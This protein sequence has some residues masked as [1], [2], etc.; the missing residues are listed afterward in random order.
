MTVNRLRLDD[1]LVVTA[2]LVDDASLAHWVLLSAP[3]ALPTVSPVRNTLN[4]P[5]ATSSCHGKLPGGLINVDPPAPPPSPS[6]AALPALRAFPSRENSWMACA[7]LCTA[8][9]EYLVLALVLDQR[10]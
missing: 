10:R 8:T 2:A 1:L 9:C 6:S 5:H 4:M 7:T 3:V